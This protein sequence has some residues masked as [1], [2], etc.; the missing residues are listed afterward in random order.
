MHTSIAY[1]IIK[2]LSTYNIH[3]DY[4]Y[5]YQ[6]ELLITGV[7]LHRIGV[8]KILKPYP[9]AERLKESLLLDAKKHTL[10]YL[11]HCIVS[12]GIDLSEEDPNLLFHLI[13]C[14]YEDTPIKP[15][16]REGLLLQAANKINT[17]VCKSEYFLHIN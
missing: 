6:G 16:I 2:C 17:S 10:T 4:S 3:P 12:G 14:A 9:E 5:S 1:L 15:M 13:C 7:L 8:L 11:T